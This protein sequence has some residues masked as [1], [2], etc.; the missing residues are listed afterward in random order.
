MCIHLWAKPNLIDSSCLRR[1]K[2]QFATLSMSIKPPSI[3]SMKSFCTVLIVEAT[4]IHGFTIEGYELD[5]TCIK[6]V[7]LDFSL[8]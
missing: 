8:P 6:E 7:N 2:V 3:L 1:K 5:P 4:A